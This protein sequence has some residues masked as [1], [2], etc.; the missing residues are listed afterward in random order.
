MS[1]NSEQLLL[2]A[3]LLHP[4]VRSAGSDTL[5]WLFLG[6][7]P[8]AHILCAGRHICTL[9]LSMASAPCA[10]K[11]GLEPALVFMDRR[12]PEALLQ[13][14]CSGEAGPQMAWLAGWQVPMQKAPLRPPFSSMLLR[15]VGT[16][17]D[18][19]SSAWSTGG[20]SATVKPGAARHA[21]AVWFLRTSSDWR[22]NGNA[23]LRNMFAN[24]SHH[25]P[26]HLRCGLAWLADK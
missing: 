8:S 24:S 9:R 21:T 25:L 15:N 11:R 7:T 1:S 22:S 14:C 3:T 5:A 23:L 10:G 12:C 2:K 26:V 4:E 17:G 13:P 19:A 20:C 16:R 18:A 6:L